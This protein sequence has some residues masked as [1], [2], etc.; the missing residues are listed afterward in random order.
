[1]CFM[2]LRHIGKASEGKAVRLRKELIAK[3]DKKRR[4][5]K[6]NIRRNLKIIAKKCPKAFKT[7]KE[8]REWINET[9]LNHPALNPHFY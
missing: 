5:W 7:G 6:K 1:M 2:R 4:R 8:K 9:T 3:M